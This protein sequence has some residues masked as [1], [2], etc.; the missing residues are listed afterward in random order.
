MILVDLS[1]AFHKATHGLVNR[2]LKDLNQKSVNLLEFK[3]EFHLTLLNIIGHHINLHKEYADEVIICLDETSGQGNWRKKIYPMYKQQR[4]KFRQQFDTFRYEDAYALFNEFID[5]MKKSKFFPV[6]DVDTCEA[7]DLIMVTAKYAA[8]KGSQVMILSPDKDFLQLQTNP[9]VKQYSWMTNKLLIQKPEEMS[10]WLLEHVCLGDT[11]DNVPRITDFTEF[12]PGV[13][14]FLI[15]MGVD[16]PDPFSFSSTFY[17][18]EDFEEFGGV[19]KRERFGLSMLKKAIDEKGSLEAFLDGN[20]VYRKNYYR[21]RQLVLEEGIPQSLREKIIHQFEN[22]HSGG[23]ASNPATLL[24]ES[25]GLNGSNLPDFLSN[26]YISE[27]QL[28]DFL[29]W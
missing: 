25:L 22:R 28:G 26:K 23:L 2:L 12:N 27:K 19:Y 8:D 17:N 6:M 11:A 10:E 5:S 20:P 18:P 21:N 3:K 9:A 4:T 7:D 13:R 14:E 16:D 1:S 15:E 29:D 24:V